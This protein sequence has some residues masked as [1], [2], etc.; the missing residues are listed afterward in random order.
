MAGEQ[1]ENRAAAALE[2]IHKVAPEPEPVAGEQL[3]SYEV[4]RPVARGGMAT[5]FAVRD[6]RDGVERALKL[7]LPL[8]HNEEAR[9]RFRRE[10]RA[11]SK[12]Q[13]PNVLQVFEWGLRGDRPWYTMELVQGSDLRELVEHWRTLDPE[14]R[15]AR[16]HAT[17]VQVCRAL[18]YIHDR[19]LVHR[20]ITPGNIMVRPDGLVKLMDFGVVKDL[21]AELTAVGEVVGTV[22]YISPEQIAGDALDARADL[23]SL[24][25]V[26]YLMLTG[27]RPFQASTL[28]GFLEKHLHEA[29]K[30]PHDIDPTI[31]TYLADICMRLL[32]KVPS[33]RYASAT[34]LLHVLGDLYGMEESEGRWPPRAVGRTR[35]RARMRDAIDDILSAKP[36]AVLLLSG[37]AGQGKTRLLDMAD[38]YAR[39][40]GLTVARGKCR[41]HDR[42]F[43]AFIGV[44]RDLATES[45]APVLRATLEGKDDGV[46]RERYP[47][48]AAFRELVVA[49]GPCLVILDDLELADPATVEMLEYLVRNTLELTQEPVVYLLAEEASNEGE[50]SVSRQVQAAGPVERFEIGPFEVSEVEELVLSL[51][52]NTPASLNLARRLHAEANGSPV[53][54]SDMLRGLQD[55]GK[56]VKDGNRYKLNFHASEISQSRL[57]MPA[58]LR[59]A[60]EDRLQ[61]LSPQALEIGRELAIARRRLDLDALI[62]AS[63]LDED[64]VM[65]GLDELIEVGIVEEKRGEDGEQIELSHH[66]FRDVLLEKLPPEERRKRHERLGA[67]LERQYRHR[68]QG[69]VEELAFH[70]E[71]A[72]LAPKAYAYLQMTATRHLNR[73]LY[74]EALGFLDRALA[75]ETTARPLMLLDDADR[76]LAEVHLER[77]QALYHLGHWPEALADIRAAEALAKEVRDARLQSRIAAELGNQLRSRGALEEAEKAL[78][79]ALAKAQE[80]GDPALRPMPLYQLGALIWGKGDLDEA[81]KLWKEALQTAQ[82]TSDERAMGFGYNGLGILAL[83]KGDSA[84]ARRFL[85]QSAELFERLG[86]LAALAIARV[87]LVEVYLSTGILRKA[88]ALADRTVGQAREVHHPHGIALGLVYRSQVLAALHRDEEAIQNARE[89]LRIVRQLG[90]AED[91]VLVLATLT[92]VDL[93][94]NAPKTALDWISA[95]LPLLTSYDSEGV[96]P[97]VYAM[98]AQ[99]LAQLG[100]LPEAEKAF[101]MSQ[102]GDRQWPHIQVRTDIAKAV[103]ARLL[104]KPD[105]AKTLLQRALSVAEPNGYRYY[106]LLAHHELTLVVSDDATRARHSRVAAAL[107]RSL[108]ANLSREEAKRFLST[109]WGG[110]RLDS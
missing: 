108:A 9:T 77:S 47:V 60:L 19:G 66:R 70:F 13:H 82:R 44:Y 41:P 78:R 45:M 54:I 11:L 31:P 105:E 14:D 89:A 38:T 53:F 2:L 62:E 95:L 65:Q 15:F 97:Q 73:S 69:I 102:H 6:T 92:R 106:Q 36:G 71:Q 1:G 104:H 91:E 107:A 101:E 29:P 52:P 28:Q 83:C 46:V 24:G 68:P 40:R 61:P 10:F 110:Q 37:E 109:E 12:L 33:D 18:A 50:T 26:L 16:A 43:G 87:N 75:M 17:L 93:L 22:A 27:R 51:L 39:R 86:M 8:A 5:V 20:D 85:E 79:A 32:A 98:H 63:A 96:A 94:R 76:R 103:A 3:G 99:A 100:R 90:T 58:S 74:D 59:Q 49:R 84:E 72:E 48:I 81:D 25:A 56:L 80:V 21:G 4:L 42:P 57:P 88:L 23:Y 64:T 30:P 34:H 67:I 35:V 7:L 55:E